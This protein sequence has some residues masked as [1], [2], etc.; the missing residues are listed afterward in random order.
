MVYRRR[1]VWLKVMDK[2]LWGTLEN[3]TTKRP[4]QKANHVPAFFFFFF[5][6]RIWL[7]FKWL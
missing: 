5:Y 3:V 2:K 6:F 4:N 1:V 7:M